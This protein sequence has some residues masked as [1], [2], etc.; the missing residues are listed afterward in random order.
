MRRRIPRDQETH[1]HS[2]D[3]PNVLFSHSS[4][5][6]PAIQWLVERMLERGL[7]VQP[8][9]WTLQTHPF[10]ELPEACS[11]IVI[12]VGGDGRGPWGRAELAAVLERAL[13][14]QDGFRVALVLLPEA[15]LDDARSLTDN[16]PWIDAR[17]GMRSAIVVDE[18][19]AVVTG[20]APVNSTVELA[21]A[22]LPYAGARALQA[23]DAPYFCGRETAIRA[24]ARNL[25]VDDF[26]AVLGRAGSGKTSLIEAG[27]A[28]ATAEDSLPEVARWPRIRISA[29]ARPLMALAVAVENSAG[30][31]AEDQ[32]AGSPAQ[33]LERMATEPAALTER[34]GRLFGQHATPVLVI[35]D[36]IDELV[37]GRVDVAERGAFFAALGHLARNGEGAFKV[38]ATIRIERVGLCRAT[39]E[40]RDLVM[41]QSLVLSGM[42]KAELR[43]AIERPARLRGA[44]VEPALVRALLEDLE[45]CEEPLSLLAWCLPTLWEQRMGRWLTEDVYR[46][47]GGLNGAMDR[48]AEAI[49]ASLPEQLRE[50]AKDILLALIEI[51]EADGPCLLTCPPRGLC[52]GTADPA[53][54]EQALEMLIG[55]RLLRERPTGVALVSD[56]LV[57]GWR[58]LTGW[59]DGVRERRIILANLSRDAELWAGEGR[60]EE[61][62]LAPR[63]LAGIEILSDAERGVLGERDLEFFDASVERN[64]RREAGLLA[65]G[66]SQPLIFEDVRVV[67]PRLGSPVLI[68]LTLV[69]LIAALLIGGYAWRQT[70][71]LELARSGVSAVG[72]SGS[73]RTVGAEVEAPRDRLL[74]TLGSERSRRKA[75]EARLGGARRTAARLLVNASRD[76]AL[77]KQPDLRLLLAVRASLVAPSGVSDANLRQLISALAAEA[78]PEIT[79]GSGHALT[80]SAISADASRVASLVAG[81]GV[82]VT[83]LS[84][85]PGAEEQAPTRLI[86]L[87]EER[88]TAL[89]LDPSGAY[90]F[91]GCSGGRLCFLNLDSGSDRLT[92]WPTPLES[93]DQLAFSP[94]GRWL[95]AAGTCV[96]DAQSSSCAAH[97]LLWEAN[98]IDRAA[99]VLADYS[100]DP[101]ALAFSPDGRF[102]VVGDRDGGVRLYAP[103]EPDAV[104]LSL[105]QHEAPVTALASSQGARVIVSADARG[106]L[107]VWSRDGEQQASEELAAL[108]QPV[109]SLALTRDGQWLAASLAEGGIRLWNLGDEGGFGLDLRAPGILAGA[110]DFVAE[111]NNLLGAGRNGGAA[112]WRMLP[113]LR[114]L[115]C[116]QAGRDL[117]QKEWRRYLGAIPYERTCRN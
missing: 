14:E 5:D 2:M 109:V 31:L 24:L 18:L 6:E 23:E 88:L 3:Q 84:P 15:A 56:V 96:A 33:L 83:E 112:Q 19:A 32:V 78:E 114:K 38:V 66:V 45:G 47:L 86:G 90:L 106:R 98:R 28:S 71:A 105:S 59:L 63:R 17:A 12:F 30:L 16:F 1:R 8:D 4:S 67:R 13:R 61:D 52:G 69:S 87:G 37:C 101:A 54:C 97:L 41:S 26:V 43:S 75:A 110:V 55:S 94:D 64:A 77:A 60:P 22:P 44:L 29:G 27:L 103:A 81:V 104:A 111:D 72:A 7:Q 100:P 49:Y 35:V 50:A 51:D 21:D 102:L 95:A 115:A 9:N 113:L 107:L 73:L 82:E 10:Y 48:S 58:R 39:P 36:A 74:E 70:N 76:P 117:T 62:L 25:M 53:R 34:L 68:G 108:S 93:V 46:E 42:T 65:E 40:L 11:C 89:A 80:R 79:P 116:K 57:H 91:L 99:R 85:L 20:R 92:A